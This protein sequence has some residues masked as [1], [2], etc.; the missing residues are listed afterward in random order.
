MFDKKLLEKYEE[1]KNERPTLNAVIDP[2]DKENLEKTAK[3]N[4]ISVSKV[5]RIIIKEFFGKKTGDKTA[6]S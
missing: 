4:N 5:V 2:K 6:K 1:P 3:E